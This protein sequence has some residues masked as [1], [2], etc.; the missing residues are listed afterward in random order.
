MAPLL[1]PD[2][3]LLGH[4]RPQRARLPSRPVSSLCCTSRTQC[5]L[6]RATMNWQTP[7]HLCFCQVGHCLWASVHITSPRGCLTLQLG[8]SSL[9]PQP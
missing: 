9:H 1:R 6:L 8:T 5:S 4:T 2:H 3:C 7:F